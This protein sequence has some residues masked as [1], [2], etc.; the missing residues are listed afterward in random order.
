LLAGPALKAAL[1]CGFI[2]ICCVG[3][4]WQKKQIAELSQQKGNAEKRRDALQA[5]NKKLAKQ[6]A[7]LVSPPALEAR[8]KEMKLGL[9]PPQPN[10]I[11]RLSVPAGEPSSPGRDPQYMAGKPVM[12]GMP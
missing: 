7:I 8:A 5:D 10:Q 4:V 6:L 11:W 3:Y 9:G 1:I 12:L 2:V